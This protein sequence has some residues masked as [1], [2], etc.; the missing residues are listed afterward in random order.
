MTPHVLPFVEEARYKNHA[1]LFI[2]KKEV[3][4]LFHDTRDSPRTLT[5][6]PQM[7]RASVTAELWPCAAPRPIGGCANISYR[8]ENENLIPIAGIP[9]K[10]GFGIHE[11]PLNFP[12]GASSDFR[13]AHS[14][15][16]CCA[17]R[18]GRKR[19]IASSSVARISALNSSNEENW[20]QRPSSISLNPSSTAAFSAANFSSSVGEPT[21]SSRS[22]SQ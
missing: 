21:H 14:A 17:A 3:A 6:Q 13:T 19:A 7:P 9:S 15:S 2:I 8:S 4:W 18:L 22:S 16:T 5:A 20:K 11:Y 12:T 1:A 10:L